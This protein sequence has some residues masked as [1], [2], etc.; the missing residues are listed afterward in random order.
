MTKFFKILIIYFIK[1]NVDF[2]SFVNN[3]WI[4]FPYFIKS[5]SYHSSTAH[6]DNFD[7]IQGLIQAVLISVFSI[8]VGSLILS[9]FQYF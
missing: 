3:L 1:F 5:A 6:L 8:S 7:Q 4:H 9:I 2:K